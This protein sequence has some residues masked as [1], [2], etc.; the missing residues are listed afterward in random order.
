MAK[1][2]DDLLAATLI[3]M[4]R[5]KSLDNITV[6]ELVTAAGVNRKT[7]YNH[8]DG[9]E[10]LLRYIV[11]N[12]HNRISTQP[13]NLENWDDRIRRAMHC[14]KANAGF[15][16]K[17][18][19]SRYLPIL[20]D[21]LRPEMDKSLRDYIRLELD[22]LERNT[23]RSYP[24]TQEQMDKLVALYSPCVNALI[25]QWHTDGMTQSIDEF[26]NIV[27]RMLAGGI[28]ACVLYFLE[29]N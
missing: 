13:T 6:T 15:T 4:S 22:L 29:E 2:I 7:F 21:W 19:Q 25:D 11:Q 9:I 28:F 3:E 26:I 8:F 20:Q 24:I 1:Q 23:G 5:T 12:N 10:G 18:Y 27:V 17:V 14:M 16:T